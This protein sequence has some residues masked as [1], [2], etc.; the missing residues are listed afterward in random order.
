MKPKVLCLMGPT[1]SGK[2]ALAMAIA[3]LRPCRLISVDSALIYCGMDIGTGKPDRLEQERYPH[4]LMDI[5]DPAESYSAARFR[6][7][8]LREIDTALAA[9]QLPVLVGGTMLYF[10]ALIEG[11]AE[12][13]DADPA[14]RER[15][16]QQRQ[17]VGLAAM[18]QRL[19]E[20]D[21]EA[22]SRIS[23]NDPQRILRALEVIEL[24][25]QSMSSLWEQQKQTSLPYRFVQVALLPDRAWLHQRIATRFD[26][27]LAAGF[28]AEVRALKQRPDLH[29][30]LPSMRCVGYR[31]IWEFLDGSGTEVEMRERGIAATRQLAKRQYT[32]LRK[33]P[34]DLK[35]DEKSENPALTV[36]KHLDSVPI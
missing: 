14:V 17:S 22:G 7:A 16:E 29:P 6:E 25:G 20:L 19:T 9:Q 8:A 34:L 36:L 31:Q 5:C 12:L 26:A 11:I 18:H 15:L 13:P 1:A 30:D 35:F 3:D 21:P 28:V 2:T 10:K 23:A 24:S 27:M 33:W 32:W 4:A